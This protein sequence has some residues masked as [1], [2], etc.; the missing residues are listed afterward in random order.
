MYETRLHKYYLFDLIC[1]YLPLYLF[2]LL[3][4]CVKFCVKGMVVT[5]KDTRGFPYD[6]A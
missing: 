5:F 2:K 1:T 4:F 3:Y 6:L